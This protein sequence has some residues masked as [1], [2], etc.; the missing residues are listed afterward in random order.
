MCLILSASALLLAII[1]SWKFQS[2]AWIMFSGEILY[3]LFLFLSW[4][5][6][7]KTLTVK[8][9][10]L[11]YDKWIKYTKQKIH[12]LGLCF[13]HQQTFLIISALFKRNKTFCKVMKIKIKMITL[14]SVSASF[15]TSFFFPV[16]R[17]IAYTF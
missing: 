10:I 5:I 12:I 11:W 1:A 13:F 16:Y 7:L 9:K 2:K 14:T 6:S 17:T 8:V 3:T 4:A 15:F